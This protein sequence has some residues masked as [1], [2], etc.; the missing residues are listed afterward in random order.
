MYAEAKT[1][2]ITAAGGGSTGRRLRLWNPEL[3][4]FADR[5]ELSVAVCHP[6]RH[7]V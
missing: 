5:A 3:Q 7:L 2:L 6:S 1:T 4:K